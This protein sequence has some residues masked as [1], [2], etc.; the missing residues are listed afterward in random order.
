MILLGKVMIGQE[1]CSS[2]C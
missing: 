2:I 1:F